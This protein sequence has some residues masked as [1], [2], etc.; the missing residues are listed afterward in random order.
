M[1]YKPSQSRVKGRR[2]NITGLDGQKYVLVDWQVAYG[3]PDEYMVYENYVP[4]D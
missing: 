3:Q 4:A 1:K 2:R